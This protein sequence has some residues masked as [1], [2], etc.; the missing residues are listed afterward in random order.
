MTLPSPNNQQGEQAQVG[1]VV[2]MGVLLEEVE[3]WA[4]SGL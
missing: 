4:T 1:M 3:V 2:I